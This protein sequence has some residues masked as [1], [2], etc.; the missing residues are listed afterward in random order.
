VSDIALALASRKG[1][2]G[3]RKNC[4]ISTHMPRIISVSK[5]YLPALSRALSVLSSHR[6]GGA[7]RKLDG[8]G[9]AGRAQRRELVEKRAFA[10]PGRE[11]NA[12]VEADIG[13]RVSAKRGFALAM[14]A[15]EVVVE[16]RERVGSW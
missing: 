3:G 2:Y 11:S 13:R 10:T 8:G 4:S 15:T 6:R 14:T 12:A 1:T 9:P 16:W 7:N 5:K